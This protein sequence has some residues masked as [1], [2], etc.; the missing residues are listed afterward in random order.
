MTAVVEDLEPGLSHKPT[1][2]TITEMH[3]M[4][5]KHVLIFTFDDGENH[6]KSIKGQKLKTR[7]LI[8]FCPAFFIPLR[9]RGGGVVNC[10]TR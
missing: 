6:K 1:A 8:L 9:S 4:I 5:S 3:A 2:I 10:P 7:T